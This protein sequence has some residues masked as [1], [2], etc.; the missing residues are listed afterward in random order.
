M[1]FCY[2]LKEEKIVTFLDDAA[3]VLE[4]AG[5]KYSK[6]IFTIDIC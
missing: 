6:L 4:L 3:T 5:L 2:P 1:L